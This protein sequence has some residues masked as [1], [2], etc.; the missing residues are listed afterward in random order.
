MQLQVLSQQ[1]LF[2]PYYLL[3][4]LVFD[5]R[6]QIFDQATQEQSV[7]L[8]IDQEIGAEDFFARFNYTDC[9]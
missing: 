6:C 9:D 1:G 8:Q 3:F 4:D 5:P 2:D 7:A